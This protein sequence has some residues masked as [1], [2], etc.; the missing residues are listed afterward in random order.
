MK[1]LGPL[2]ALA[3]LA[4]PALGQSTPSDPWLRDV[5]SSAKLHEQRTIYVATPDGYL[6]NNERYPVLVLLDADDTPQFSLAVANVRFLASRNAIPPLIVVGIANGK[7]R[8]H[9]M[10]P[11]A[12]GASAKRFA[13]AGGAQGLAD[14]I[15][16]EVLPTIRSKYRTLPTTILAG[17]SFGGLF[18]LH[19]AAVRPND[20]VGIVA[21]SPSLWWNDSTAAA[22]YADSIANATATFRLFATSGGLEEAIDRTARRFESR[23]DS[24]R[25]ANLSFGYRRYPDDTHG[26][27]P[28]PSLADGL[29]FVFEPVSLIKMAVSRLRPGVDSADVVKA[30][31]ET[32]QSY[33]AGARLLKLPER[34]P[35]Q[36]LNQLG[37]NVLT[38]LNK[39]DLALWIFRRNIDAYPESANVYD[40]FADALLVKGDTVAARAQ[41]KRAIDIALRTSDPV[42]EGSRRKLDALDKAAVQAGKPKPR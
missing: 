31:L 36:V 3:I 37:Y 8:T 17:H 7:D 40:S 28:A 27:T 16:D 4:S 39:P 26:L 19:V 13:T 33:A 12:T 34:L 6:R 18:A 22:A 21:M 15:G 29:R 11:V 20:Y 23:L 32:E 1:T 30:V 25:P 24:I 42:L 9:D 35:E 2:T 38:G 10:T 14:F 5:I 41:L